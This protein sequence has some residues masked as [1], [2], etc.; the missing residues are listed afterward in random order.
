MVYKCNNYRKYEKFR[1]NIK[2]TTFYNVTIIYTLPNKNKKSEYYFKVDHSDECN[3]LSKE[4][5][6]Y[7][8]K[9]N[10]LK[11]LEKNIFIGECEKI[12]NKSSKYDRPLFK[13][14]FKD[15]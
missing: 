10:G 1:I 6:S 15:I 3:N 2:Y 5:H 11:K 12:M 13:E 7:N 8:V 14:K 9:Q 4:F